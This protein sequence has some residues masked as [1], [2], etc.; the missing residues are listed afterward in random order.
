MSLEAELEKIISAPTTKAARGRKLIELGC[1]RTDLVE[2]L[3]MT[4]GQAHGL[5]KELHGNND[6]SARASNRLPNGRRARS[7]GA[8]D[9]LQSSPQG[10]GG[11]RRLNLRPA[12]TRVI[13]QDGHEV[14]RDLAGRNCTECDNE[15]TFSL[16]HLG[17]VHT[18]S[19]KEPT[20]LEDNYA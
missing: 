18:S 19:K 4:Y 10:S 12:Q 14:L 7:G 9:Q 6:N 5:W 15:I 3:G 2:L 17:F 8:N 13:T 1:E 11:L 20:K 16:R